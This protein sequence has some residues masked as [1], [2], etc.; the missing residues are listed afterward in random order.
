VIRLNRESEGFQ[1]K[2]NA[3]IN[4]GFELIKMEGSNCVLTKVSEPDKAPVKKKIPENPNIVLLKNMEKRLAE[5]DLS[6]SV[7]KKFNKR[8]KKLKAKK[9]NS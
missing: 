4:K 3:L 9:M 7:V 2:Y 8:I 6:S 5:E 1:E